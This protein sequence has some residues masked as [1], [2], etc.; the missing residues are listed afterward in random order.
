[1]EVN[2]E[3]V[4]ELW[5]IAHSFVPHPITVAVF[6]FFPL[7]FSSGDALNGLKLFKSVVMAGDKNAFSWLI[8]CPDSTSHWE[9]LMAILTAGVW[10][11][12]ASLCHVVESFLAVLVACWAS[13]LATLRLL[14][15]IYFQR[16]DHCFEFLISKF[17]TV[18]SLFQIF[19]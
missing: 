7:L 13:L 9:E 5:V 3:F 4:S 1:M 8:V 6:E 10:T 19:N 11:L 15:E 14:L 12:H 16:L 17:D 2:H 18:L